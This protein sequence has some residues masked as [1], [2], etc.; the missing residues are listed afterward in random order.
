MSLEIILMGFLVGGLV[1]M[2]GVGGASIL[3]P[4]LVFLGINPAV[5]I[6][7][8]FAYNSITKLFGAV[9]HIRQKTVDFQLVKFLAIGSIPV[10]ILANLLF[11]YFFS[12]H[13]HEDLIVLLLGYVLILVSVITLVQFFIR[14]NSINYWKMKSLKDKRHITIIAGMIIGAI[15]G[16]TS[17][18][19]GSLFALFILY[20]YNLKSSEVVG[21]DITHAF[22]LVTLVGLLM[23]GLG[24]IDYFLVGN[25]LCGSIPGAIIGS[26]L[27]EKV[28]SNVLRF[29]I[30]TVILIS[31]MTLILK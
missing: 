23:A 29:I 14:P 30:V 31:G 22:L 28:P 2:T 1:G 19:S 7:T 18:G 13:Y 27:T 3:T 5:A 15:V 9:Q 11:Y 20:F 21:T 25:L 6:G 8:D 4:I 24:H 10:A 16:I 12:S 17:V 26:K